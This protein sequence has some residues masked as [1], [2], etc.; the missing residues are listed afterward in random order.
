MSKQIVKGL[1]DK[2]KTKVKVPV[3]D[4]KDRKSR[5]LTI[6]VT[7][8]LL[9]R[10]T[11][12]SQLRE[13]QDEVEEHGLDVDPERELLMENM[14]A[15]EGVLDQDDKPIPFTKDGI[16]SVLDASQ[17]FE[18]IWDAFVDLQTSKRKERQKN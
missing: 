18:A 15:W 11:F 10:S 9:G 1:K 4:E 14:T 8:K 2:V 7:F 6:W 17:Y 12:R 3:F 16:N 13:A 5:F